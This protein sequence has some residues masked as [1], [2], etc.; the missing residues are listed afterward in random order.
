MRAPGLKELGMITDM[1]WADVDLDEDPDMVVVGDWMPVKVFI[2]EEGQFT[3][4]SDSW[5]LSGTEGWWNR[6]AA[7]DLDGDGDTDLVLGN[8]GLNSR[9]R[10]SAE[11]P[12]TMY[13]N[14]FDL[15]GRVEQIICAFNGDT[16]LSHGHER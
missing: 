1:V 11:K 8:H 16:C 6:V 4:R 15:N 13:V 9:F 7:E 10:A 12:V 3:D 2:N 14:D 5:G